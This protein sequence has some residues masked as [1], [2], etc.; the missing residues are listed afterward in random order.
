MERYFE[1]YN[2]PILKTIKNY[3]GIQDNF[4]A[5]FQEKIFQKRKELKI[6]CE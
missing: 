6:S 2:I 4:L 3:V 5:I 1:G